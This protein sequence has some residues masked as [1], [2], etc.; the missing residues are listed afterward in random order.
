MIT[1]AIG[2]YPRSFQF[3]Q[4]AIVCE[5]VYVNP[6]EAA[7]VK[8]SGLTTLAGQKTYGNEHTSNQLSGERDK[9]ASS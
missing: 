2:G 7:F 4:N 1:T 5:E 6:A 8:G 9:P 3:D